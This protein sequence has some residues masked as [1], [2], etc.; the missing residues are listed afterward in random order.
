MKKI[1]AIALIFVM[2]CTLSG[3]RCLLIPDGF[4]SSS[5]DTS[6]YVEIIEPEDNT[7][8]FK[9]GNVSDKA[10]IEFI[11]QSGTVVLTASDIATVTAQQTEF[12][13][14][15]LLLELTQEG[16]KKF[17][18]ATSQNIGKTISIYI[19]GEKIMSPTVEDAITDGK[20]LVS[21][22]E[23]KEKLLSL[24]ESLT[25]PSIPEPILPI[26]E[27]TSFYFSSGAGGWGTELKLNPDGSFTGCYHDSDMGDMGDGYPN[28][29]VYICN[30]SGKFE[31]IKKID[32]Y[33]YQMTLT[34][35]TIEETPDEWI[36]E[37]VKYIA[38]GP[39]GIEGGTNF[40]FYMPNTPISR[41]SEEF[42]SWWPGR[43]DLSEP[44]DTLTGYGILN[45][46]T[47]EGFF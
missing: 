31:N 9:K 27:V 20:V 14:Y 2:I 7:I 25:N 43:F 36:E 4:L 24:Y 5:E 11:D 26:E 16:S 23:S 38:S 19:D 8:V 15:S 17:A 32:E 45:V 28:G 6:S 21:N 30:F 35:L 3:C 42:L 39:Y 13:M 47:Q 37:G 41:L 22:F 33:S 18:T 34:N 40:I 29:T 12:G 10:N 46:E 1:L 44:K